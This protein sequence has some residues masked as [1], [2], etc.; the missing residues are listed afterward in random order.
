VTV[1]LRVCG[2]V[3]HDWIRNANFSSFIVPEYRVA[4]DA[5]SIGDGAPSVDADGDSSRVMRQG[6]VVGRDETVFGTSL[7][8][9]PLLRVWPL[10]VRAVPDDGEWDG[11]PPSWRDTAWQAVVARTLPWEAAAQC[12][13][14]FDP[15]RIM[16]HEECYATAMRESDGG[17]EDPELDREAV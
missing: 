16:T 13:R 9:Q 14:R 11:A 4:V 17:E 15:R 10:P 2:A 8:E 12:G 5:A 3:P 7:T 1:G 6:D